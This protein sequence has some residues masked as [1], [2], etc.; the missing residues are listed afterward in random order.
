MSPINASL[1]I[2]CM[3][4]SWSSMDSNRL[5]VSPGSMTATSGSSPCSER[6]VRI[7]SPPIRR[8]HSPYLLSLQGG[9]NGGG[10]A[11][12]GSGGHHYHHSRYPHS[13]TS[14]HRMSSLGSSLGHQR[15]PLVKQYSMDVGSDPQLNQL[16]LNSSLPDVCNS[17]NNNR[18]KSGLP[19]YYPHCQQHIQQQ[20]QQLTQLFRGRHKGQTA[21]YRSQPSLKDLKSGGPSGADRTSGSLDSSNPSR[22]GDISSAACSDRVIPARDRFK[23]KLLRSRSSGAKYSRFREKYKQ[24]NLNNNGHLNTSDTSLAKE[25]GG[26]IGGKQ[27]GA[28]AGSNRTGSNDTGSDVEESLFSD[29]GSEEAACD[30]E[31]KM[32]TGGTED[33]EDDIRP[34]LSPYASLDAPGGPNDAFNTANRRPSA[35]DSTG[36]SS[37]S[38]PRGENTPHLIKQTS[39]PKCKSPMPPALKATSRRSSISSSNHPG[40]DNTS[41]EMGEDNVQ[42]HPHPHASSYRVPCKSP[43]PSAVRRSNSFS[44][45]KLTPKAFSPPMISTRSDRSSHSPYQSISP[46]AL[47]PSPLALEDS[48]YKLRTPEG[49]LASS[50]HSPVPFTHSNMLTVPSPHSLY[51]YNMRSPS[52]TPTGKQVHLALPIVELGPSTGSGSGPGGAAA[53]S[54]IIRRQPS[55]AFRR[56]QTLS[57]SFAVDESGPLGSPPSPS[58]S[59]SVSPSVSLR[60]RIP[61]TLSVDSAFLAP[62]NLGHSSPYAIN[63][64]YLEVH[65]GCRAPSPLPSPRNSQQTLPGMFTR[66]TSPAIPVNPQQPQQQQTRSP[67]FSSPPLQANQIRPEVSSPPPQK[68]KQQHQRLSPTMSSSP[69]QRPSQQQ[70]KQPSFS[71]LPPPSKNELQQLQSEQQLNK[72]SQVE[73]SIPTA[74][75]TSD[76]STT[77]LSVPFVDP[78]AKS[79]SQNFTSDKENSRNEPARDKS[80]VQPEEELNSSVKVS[81]EQTNEEELQNSKD[82]SETDL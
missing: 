25:K 41:F 16:P 76:A 52:P 59:S 45:S 58:A 43:R 21:I 79:Q 30:L 1:T 62:P 2:E 18:P 55:P 80:G 13:T 70:Q 9:G 4:S 48:T 7:S 24:S 19:P 5:G 10:G 65:A 69:P 28:A 61:H 11:G 68:Q 78:H 15:R 22:T 31:V 36:S 35:V 53:G 47:P 12:G 37:A 54:G 64:P 34:T 77:C 29:W 33:E 60:R 27:R 66:S 71:I 26:S 42:P 74:I 63:D 8:A 49:G 20:Q 51:P 14:Q 17:H 32:I 73:T 57:R 3:A 56:Q 23:H 75:A 50:G 6:S 39:H 44:P 82:K 67:S 46:L 38:T 72:P 40:I 81:S